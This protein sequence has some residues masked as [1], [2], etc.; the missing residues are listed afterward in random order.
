MQSKHETPLIGK[1]QNEQI[2][3]EELA[4]LA[5]TFN[6]EFVCDLGKRI[7]RVYVAGGK[8]IGTKDYFHDQYIDFK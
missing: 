8:I 5:G 4:E 7:P 1:D 2:T 3:V 6:Y